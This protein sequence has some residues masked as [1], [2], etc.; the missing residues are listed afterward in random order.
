M[1]R[2]RSARA[3]SSTNLAL[4]FALALAAAG[5]AEELPPLAR[6][7]IAEFETALAK[8]KGIYLVLDPS[9]PR[10]TIKSRGLALADIELTEIHLLEF[11]PL[12]ARGDSP[13]L[14][15]PA[16]WK[17]AQGPGDTDRETIA[18]PELRPYS[19][20]E[21]EPEPSAPAGASGAPAK[22]AEEG[23]KPSTYRVGL[24]NGWQ[25]YVTPKSP[26]AGFFRRLGAAVHDGWLR[27]RGQEPSHPPLVALVMPPESAQRLHHLFRT[28]TEILVLP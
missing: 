11:R 17:I 8:G 12:F 20:N 9:A 14:E 13:E 3:S 4:A 25:L 15:A 10:L 5:R 7:R 21:E 1:K 18:P 27:V 16:V 28:G 23:E 24:E 19:E 6:L 22:K 2:L 26:R